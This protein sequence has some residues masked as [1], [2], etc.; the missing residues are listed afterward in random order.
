MKET[1]RSGHQD[2]RPGGDHPGYILK[3]DVTVH[4]YGYV[5]LAFIEEFPAILH[6]VKGIGN[7][8]LTGETGVYGHDEDKIDPLQYICEGRDRCR[9]IKRC[10]SFDPM[11]PDEQQKA[12]KMNGRFDV[13]GDLKIHG[14]LEQTIDLLKVDLGMGEIPYWV[15]GGDLQNCQVARLNNHK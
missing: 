12:I 13:N 4:P 5:Q 11:F 6:L 9:W 2:I 3:A 14:A 8:L 15:S 1:A 10:P 7:C